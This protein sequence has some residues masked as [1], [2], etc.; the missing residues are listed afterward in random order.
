[1]NLEEKYL[2]ALRESKSVDLESVLKK[3]VDENNIKIEDEQVIEQD[4][5]FDLKRKRVLWI[6]SLLTLI[7]TILG[8]YHVKTIFAWSFAST[9]IPLGL[10]AVVYVDQIFLPGNSIK[11]LSENG[12]AVAV[13]FVGLIH[14][15][16]WSVD[17]GDNWIGGAQTS[18]IEESS[19]TLSE[20]SSTYG[21]I[22]L[23][24]GDKGESVRVK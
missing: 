12:I 16:T 15:F 14:L 10:L 18:S 11:K 22:T 2:Q 23:D 6:A 3:A 9:L 24:V 5:I 1:M 4:Q 17:F 13:C 8:F 7:I 21:R 19:E 20:S